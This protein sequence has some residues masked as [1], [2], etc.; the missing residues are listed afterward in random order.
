MDAETVRQFLLWIHYAILG[1]WTGGIFL[2]IFAASPAVGYSMVS[3]TLAAQIE[4]RMCRR[5]N[6]GT[7]SGCLVLLGVLFSFSH[8]DSE[9]N[10]ALVKLFFGTVVMGIF[11]AYS[12]FGLLPRVKSLGETIPATSTDSP[13]QM[14]FDR[15]LRVYRGLQ[16]LTG[17]LGLFILYGSV[18]TF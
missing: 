2:I 10:T 17:V 9:K 13:Q 3:K 18:V 5:F 8:L 12:A 7:L 6:L 14:E 16:L 4:T 11:T 1:G 15:L